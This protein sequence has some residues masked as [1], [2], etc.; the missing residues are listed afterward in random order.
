MSLRFKGGELDEYTVD[1]IV[2]YYFNI[3]QHYKSWCKSYI[4]VKISSFGLG[5]L[6]LYSL[7]S[8]VVSWGYAVDGIAYL[9]HI[10]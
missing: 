7:E 9:S 3:C 1:V 4:E 8:R 6:K 5:I 2:F 10:S